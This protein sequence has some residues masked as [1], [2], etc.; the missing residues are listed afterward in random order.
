VRGLVHAFPKRDHPV[1]GAACQVAFPDASDMRTY[2]FDAP[3]VRRSPVNAPVPVTSS[4]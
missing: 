3:V 1:I 4:L 2:Q